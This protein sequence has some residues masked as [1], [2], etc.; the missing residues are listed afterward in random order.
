MLLSLSLGLSGTFQRAAP[1]GP[2]PGPLPMDLSLESFGRDR[3]VYDSGAGFGRDAARL[4]LTGTATPGAA[5][6]GR[7]LVAENDLPHTGWSDIATADAQGV[8]SGDLYGPRHPGWL[9]VQ[10]RLTANPSV[11]ARMP[12]VCAIG[13]VVGMLGQSELNQAFHNGDGVAL[14][15]A[16]P[17]QIQI[18]RQDV[19]SAPG[20]PV[21]GFA[22]DRGPL[23]SLTGHGF[24]TH[25]GAVLAGATGDK[26]MVIQMALSGTGRWYLSDDTDALPTNRRR[27]TDHL[28]TLDE[29]GGADG[30][31]PGLIVDMWTVTDGRW[32]ADFHRAFTPF[33]TGKTVEGGAYTLG[34]TITVPN[35]EEGG[36]DDIRHDHILFDLTGQGRGQYDP[37]ETRLVICNHRHD[38]SAGVMANW[39]G[40]EDSDMIDKFIWGQWELRR[41]QRMMLDT[42]DFQAIAIQGPD[43]QNY[44]NGSDSG[45]TWSDMLHPNQDGTDGLALFSR[46]LAHAAVYGLGLI[47]RTVPQIDTAVFS[48]AGDHAEFGSSAGPLTTTRKLRGEPELDDAQPHWTEFAGFAFNGV[49]VDRTESAPGGRIRVH[50]PAERQPADWSKDRFTLGEVA[51]V[52]S[53]ADPLNGWWKNYP[54]VD[55]GVPGLSGNNGVAVRPAFAELAAPAYSGAAL[56]VSESWFED[57]LGIGDPGTC[58][59][60]RFEW[61]GSVATNVATMPLFGVGTR[62]AVSVSPNR[63]LSVQVWGGGGIARTRQG[64]IL[65]GVRYAIVALVDIAARRCTVYLDPVDLA[66]PDLSGQTPAIDMTLGGNFSRFVNGDRINAFGTAPGE[67]MGG[68]F[69]SFAVWRNDLSRAGAARVTLTAMDGAAALNAHPWHRGGAISG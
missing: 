9:Q 31:R 13:H 59:T 8:W 35:M 29:A 36:V 25:A 26:V 17:E 46:H 12:R 54:V 65:P 51:T 68:A 42:A 40:R 19:A 32:G 55:L 60:A 10:T 21:T 6:Q 24:M 1:A 48:P 3:N 57:P 53:Q 7:L 58:S 34:D 44:E 47:P 22:T 50:V 64:V 20:D 30:V 45:G 11:T 37:D 49:P 66:A 43:P 15:P 56:A 2:G 33:Y 38:S 27:W 14:V 5:V 62:F 52:D 69:G 61:C 41:Q 63:Q 18:V 4:P 23:G 67:T 16:D 39:L 28:A